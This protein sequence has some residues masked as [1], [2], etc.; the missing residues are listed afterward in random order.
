MGTYS[1][2]NKDM[3]SGSSC[4]RRACFDLSWFCQ[5][6]FY[7]VAVGGRRLFHERKVFEVDKA[8]IFEDCSVG[9]SSQGNFT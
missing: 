2:T 8:L 6:R 4:G 9:L 7:F 1:L 5:S 3:E